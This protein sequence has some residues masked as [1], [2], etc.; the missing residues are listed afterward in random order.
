MP[1]TSF[2]LLLRKL[3]GTR[4]T[5]ATISQFCPRK[6]VTTTS[7]LHGIFDVLFSTTDGHRMW[8]T[9]S[10]RIA[11]AAG[12]F[13]VDVFEERDRW[14]CF[15]GI[16]PPQDCVAGLSLA[17]RLKALL[18]SVL[19]SIQFVP[20]VYE[21]IRCS[22]PGVPRSVSCPQPTCRFSH[23]LREKVPFTSEVSPIQ[24]YPSVQTFVSFP[25]RCIGC[26]YRGIQFCFRTRQ[27]HAN[28]T[29]TLPQSSFRGL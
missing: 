25:K 17:C 4:E 15:L 1:G 23:T 8:A 29:T 10:N 20:V 9:V 6:T 13:F 12:S 11:C 28:L 2:P 18:G 24:A 21:C 5:R 19:D 16:S 3:Q 7:T 27:C 22:S 14:M 26:L